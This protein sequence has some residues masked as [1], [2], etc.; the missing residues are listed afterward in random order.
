[1][2]KYR[3]NVAAIVLDAE[4]NILI[5]ER[6]DHTAWG[7]PQGGIEAGE[8]SEA[9]LVRELSEELGITADD[10]E[11]VAKAPEL[12]RYDF[13]A[14][15]VFRDWTF[16]GQEQ[17]YFLVRLHAGVALDFTSFPEEVEFLQYKPVSLDTVKKM[18]FGFKNN[19]YHAALKFFEKDMLK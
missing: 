14:D 12:L 19:V 1:M 16:V 9:A 5:F 13:P 10:F 2:E 17:Q 18:D 7:F 11:I 3:K 4:N 8:S 15:M 6:S